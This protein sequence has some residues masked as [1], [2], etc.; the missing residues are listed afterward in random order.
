MRN[1]YAD[2]DAE[3]FF[4]D[5]E[6]NGSTV[7]SVTKA[8]DPDQFWVVDW[9]SIVAK[10]SDHLRIIFGD[11]A[12]LASNTVWS[13]EFPTDAGFQHIRFDPPIYGQKNQQMTVHLSGGNGKRHLNV[14]YR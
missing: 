2:R 6:V 8:A 3:A 7:L 5:E 4:G 11:P 9:I 14:R 1:N 10:T 12:D 13:V